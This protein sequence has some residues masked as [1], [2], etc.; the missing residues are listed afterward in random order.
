MPP[1]P[2]L[3]NTVDLLVAHALLDLFDIPRAL[4][5]L[6]ALLKPTAFLYAT[7]NFDGNTILQPEIDRIVDDQIEAAYHATMDARIIDGLPSGDSR[8][9][10]HLFGHVRDAGLAIW[11]PV[12][13]I[14]LSLLK[15]RA[16]PRTKPIFC[17]LSLKPCVGRCSRRH[18][19][20]S[21]TS[22][23][24]SKNATIKLIVANWSILRT[25]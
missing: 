3:Q 5:Q 2:E 25:S 21:A 8:T 22:R 13:P 17:I 12:A 16:I 11:P 10:R 4:G 7:I 19:L 24:G 15:N 6:Q 18:N 1:Q 14:G 9:G 23:L 20:I